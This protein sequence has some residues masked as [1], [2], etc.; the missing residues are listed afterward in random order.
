MATRPSFSPVHGKCFPQVWLLRRPRSPRRST[1]TSR[2]GRSSGN[3]LDF[4]RPA[5]RFSA[6]WREQLVFRPAFAR[7][8]RRLAFGC[9]GPVGGPP[10]LRPPLAWSTPG[11]FLRPA[12]RMRGL[13]PRATV[14]AGLGPPGWPRSLPATHQRGSSIRVATRLCRFPCLGGRAVLFPRAKEGTN[15]KV[16]ARSCSTW[17][18]STES[19]LER[20]RRKRRASGVG[21]VGLLG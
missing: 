18:R 19:R 9:G 6:P 21:L 3:R 20:D 11:L 5:P 1:R 14:P 8:R 12:H 16:K 13:A 4:P 17:S 7:W 15:W 2:H 10:F